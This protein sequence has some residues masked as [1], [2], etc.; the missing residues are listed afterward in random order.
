[1]AITNFK[2]LNG[3]LDKVR[4][5]TGTGVPADTDT[6]V[7]NVNKNKI[8]TEYLDLTTGIKYART[9]VSVP[10]VAANYVAI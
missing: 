6:L 1:M 8:G 2:R 7:T 10:P 3:I 5:Y 9:A 4:S